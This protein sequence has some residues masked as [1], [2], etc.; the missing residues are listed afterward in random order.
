MLKAILFAVAGF[1]FVAPLAQEANE[2]LSSGSSAPTTTVAPST[3]A[4]AI[5]AAPTT[6][7]TT[8]TT[9]DLSGVDWDALRQAEIDSMRALHGPCGEWHDLAIQV[10]WKEEDWPMLGTIL[11]RESNCQPEVFNGADAGLTQINQIHKQWLADFGWSHPDDMLDPEKNLTFAL[12]LY[13]ASGWKPWSFSGDVPSE[14]RKCNEWLDLA[15]QVGWPEAELS[16]LSYV[17]WRESRCNPESYN[18]QDPNGGSR[19]LVQINGFWCR[20]NKYDPKGFLQSSGILN[21]C[22]D[23]YDPETNLRGALAIWNYGVTTHGYGWG[24]WNV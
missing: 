18:A 12:Y 3:T 15:R 19:G 24:P 10:G 7:S 20:P 16:K 23:L 14:P 4:P 13:E 22:D 9:V 6:T 5:T 17:M 8:T 1:L 21:E 11:R 2:A